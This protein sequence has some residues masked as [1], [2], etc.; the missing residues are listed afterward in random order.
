MAHLVRCVGLLCC[1]WCTGGLPVWGATALAPHSLNFEQLSVKDGLAQETVTAIVQDQLGYMWFG[2]QHGLSRYDGYR[3]TVFRTIPNDPRSLADNWVQVLHVDRKNRL[4]V[5]TRGGLQRFDAATGDFTRF[6]APSVT[7][8]ATASASA[9]QGERGRQQVQAI[10]SDG[11]GQ[12]WLGTND[13]VHHFDPESGRY[14]VLRHDPADPASLAGNQVNAL[15]LDVDGALWVGLKAGLDRLPAGGRQFQHYRVDTPAR[16]SAPLNEVQQLHIDQRR[17]LWLVTLDGLVSWQLGE[18]AAPGFARHVFGPADGL[19]PGLVTALLQDRDNTLWVGTNTDGLHRWDEAQRRFMAMPADPRQGAGNEVSNLFQ[20]Y[21]GTLWVGTWTAGVRRVDLASGGFSRYFHIPGDA[22]TLHDNRVYGIAGD[23]QGRLLLAGLGG[24]DRLDPATGRVDR[25]RGDARLERHMRHKELVLAVYRDLRGVTW[26]GSSAELGRFDPATGAYRPHLFAGTDPNSDS[27]T[28]INGDRAGNLWVGSRGGLHRID[29]GG[30]PDITYRNDGRDPASLGDDWVRMTAQD[31]RGDIWVATDNGLNLLT[32]DGKGFRHFRHDPADVRSLSSDRVQALFV[33]RAGTLWVGTN[34]G[35]NRVERGAAGTVQFRRYTARD[36]LADDAIGAMLEDDDGRL[37]LSTAAGISRLDTRLGT[38]KN[39]SVRDGMIDGYYFSGSAWRDQDGTMYFG[40]VNGLTAFQPNAI[41]DN[42]TPPAVAVTAVQAGGKPLRFGSAAPVLPHDTAALTFEFAALH[43]ADPQRNRFRYR[44]RGYDAGWTDS[45]ASK[46]VATYTNLD[47]G[48]YAFQVQAANKDGVWGSPSPPLAF[49]VAAPF[50]QRWWFRLACLAV[51]ALLVWAA[52][53]TRA[54]MHQRR[55]R[56]LEVEVRA[57][58]AEV[59]QQKEALEHTQA[60]LQRY[61]EDRERLFTAISHD[62]R[63]P[64]TRL[65]LRSELLDDDAV[66]EEFHD[67][68]DDLDMMVKGALQ[69]VK[70]TDIHE[71]LTA[72]RL[73]AFIG[74]LLRSAQLAGH[75]IDFTPAGLVVLARPLALK[76]AIGNLLDNALFY[77][78]E[79]DEGGVAIVTER[80]DTMVC[81]RIRDH[82]PGVPE[83]DLARLLEPHVRLDHGRAQNA[84]GLGLGLGIARGL[85]QAQ[86]G[87]LRLENHAAGGLLVTVMLPDHTDS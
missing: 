49:Q 43:Y 7:A 84:G 13:G 26:I 39:Y 10:I 87:V 80:V 81:I 46:R 22:H 34:G 27:I 25:L 79:S 56:Q 70:D 78:G 60:Q 52:D 62:L 32:A 55:R 68:L 57:R 72:V 77:G 4:W 54:R 38:F 37:W 19:A 21:S 65:K 36:G 66:R 76:R 48:R 63:T 53:R 59:Q 85:V 20:D 75:R 74:R 16:P 12:L 86:G 2:S 45:D 42:P 40:G 50:W 6:P 1:L 30:G 15:A 8:P 67:D 33:D 51:L 31:A 82:G 11:Y 14:T 58:T 47:P 23:G 28:H 35:L 29:A 44:L 3:V 41:R 69:T 64:I 83:A 18:G 5:G 24:I 17:V 71:N 73:D 9:Q 61:V